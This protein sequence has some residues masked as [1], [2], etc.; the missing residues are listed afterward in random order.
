MNI[1]ADERFEPD[2]LQSPPNNGIS[3]ILDH[4]PAGGGRSVNFFEPGG[5][6]IYLAE[7]ASKFLPHDGARTLPTL[8]GADVAMGGVGPMSEEANASRNYL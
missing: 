6:L 2:C 5:I 7:N 4:A 1:L 3:E 8:A